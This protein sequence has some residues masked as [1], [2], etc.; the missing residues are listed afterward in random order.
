MADDVDVSNER[1][2]QETQRR[3]KQVGAEIPPGN[4]GDCE[5][6]GEWSGRLINGVCAPCRDKFKVGGVFR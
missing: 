2:E 3:I 5:F 1:I 4:P 6:C